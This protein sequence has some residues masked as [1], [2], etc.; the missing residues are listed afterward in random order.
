[1]ERS[2][3]DRS[4]LAWSPDGAW[5]ADGTRL[6]Y[7]VNDA[8]RQRGPVHAGRVEVIGVDVPMRS[9]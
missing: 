8:V 9:Q 2:A 3:R 6:A 5:S 7:G 4:D 1:M